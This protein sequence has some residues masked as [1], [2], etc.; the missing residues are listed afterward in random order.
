MT[1]EKKELSIRLD[2]LYSE[3]TGRGTEIDKLKQ[4]AP[5]GYYFSPEE[6]R[7]WYRANGF[8][9]NIIDAPA[10]DATREWI[11]IKTN[12]DREDES[13]SISRL[14]QNRL[15]ELGFRE[16]LKDLIRFSRLYQEGGFMFFGVTSP[17]PQT[18]L[19]LYQPLPENITKIA[20]INVFGP[21]SVTLYDKITGPLSPSYHIPEIKIDGREI[22]SSRYAWLCPS[23]V[24]ED[25]RG[26]NVLETVISSIVAQ[27]TALHAVSSMLLEAGA[28]IFKT[29]KVDELSDPANMR[30]LLRK[31]VSMLTSQSIISIADNEEITRLETNL[32]AT[33]LKDTF[34]FVFENMAGMARLPKSRL[35]GQAQ[36]TITSGQFDLRSYYDDIARDQENDHRPIIEKVI[37]LVIRERNGEIYRRLNGRVEDLDWEFEFNPLWKLNEKEDAEIKL[38][39]ARTADI[40]IKN[41]VLSPSEAKAE[42]FPDLEQFPAWTDGSNLDFGESKNLEETEKQGPEKQSEVNASEKMDAPIL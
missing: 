25:G 16:K 34:Q 26:V 21:D 28:K 39:K 4:L 42:N 19:N 10:E 11:T 13:S 29:G 12:L 24:A 30:N 14:I 20:Y 7:N 1:A 27:D 18:S 9:A 38:I 15:T 41:A 23:Y 33:G 17:I 40:W 22:H 32:N 8:L 5:A 37:K 6:C 3:I 31:I 35:S 2:E 36:G